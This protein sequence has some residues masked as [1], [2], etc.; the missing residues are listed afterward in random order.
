MRE[1]KP[2][3]A[4]AV[5]SFLL[6]LPLLALSPEGAMGASTLHFSPSPKGG[7]RAVVVADGR[8]L[9][10]LAAPSGWTAFK[11]ARAVAEVLEALSGDARFDPASVAVRKS[12]AGPVILGGGRKIVTVTALDAK[13]A[14]LPADQLASRW[15]E[16]IKRTFSLPHI[17]VWPERLAVGIGERVRF[18]VRAVPP[19]IEAE[20]EPPGVVSVSVSP[21]GREVVV[22]GKSPGGAR[23]VVSNSAGKLTVPVDSRYRAA[24]LREQPRAVVTSIE[25]SDEVLKWAGLNAAFEAVE[26]REGARAE[27]LPVKVLREEGRPGALVSIV[28]E[29]PDYLPWSGRLLILPAV[30]PLGLPEPKLLAVSNWPERVESAGPLLAQPL[31]FR[32]PLRLLYHHLNAAG[33]TLEFSVDL[34]NFGEEPAQVQVVP[35]CPEP[36]YSPLRSGHVAVVRYFRRRMGRDSFVAEVGPGRRCKLVSHIV[37]PGQV[38][39]GIVEVALLSDVQVALE[40]RASRP[41]ETRWVEPLREPD[42]PPDHAP[43]VYPEPLKVVRAKAKVGESWLYLDIGEEPLRSLSSG[44][45]LLG[46]YGVVHR[47]EVTVENPLD[48]GAGVPLLFQPRGGAAAGTF[49]IEGQLKHFGAIPPWRR[50]LVAVLS[51]PP[52][53]KRLI[54]VLTMPEPGS[55]YPASLVFKTT[56]GNVGN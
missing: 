30:V 28:A 1:R 9:F 37:R 52:R 46:N 45:V 4:E 25:P 54:E 17:A 6:L 26:L 32:K 23:V 55:S 2:G 13:L 14:G 42:E 22:E 16:A 40:V 56:G 36:E 8:E 51:L 47:F 34:L 33:R 5:L 44:H 11:R 38:I 7:G 43:Y 39:S 50:K 48:E 3:A 21:G 29:G 12:E 31:A 18:Y 41:G 19:E 49:V 24:R 27:A 15:A 53:S 10:E 20:A 35:A